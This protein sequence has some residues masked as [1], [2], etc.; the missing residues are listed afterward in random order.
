MVICAMIQHSFAE[1]ANVV[2]LDN[3]FHWLVSENQSSGV[4]HSHSS[5]GACNH[6]GADPYLGPGRLWWDIG[7]LEKPLSVVDRY[8]LMNGS[9]Y[10]LCNHTER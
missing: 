7:E 6:E 5:K 3:T 1:A 4:Q 2:K 10:V 8:G 9:V